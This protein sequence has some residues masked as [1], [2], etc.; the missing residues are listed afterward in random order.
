[1]SRQSRTGHT[2]TLRSGNQ[3]RANVERRIARERRR[4]T[5]VA[6]QFVANLRYRDSRGNEYAVAERSTDGRP[7]TLRLYVRP[8]RPLRVRRGRAAQEGG[9]RARALQRSLLRTAFSTRTG[10][11]LLLFDLVSR[12]RVSGRVAS[13]MRG[14]ERGYGIVVI[15]EIQNLGPPEDPAIFNLTD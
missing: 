5:N 12:E 3:S 14:V 8:Q 6:A 15:E 7:G 2:G 11:E 9:M 1:M 10:D 4:G 13:T